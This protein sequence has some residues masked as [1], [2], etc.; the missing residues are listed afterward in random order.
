MSNGRV[1]SNTKVIRFKFDSHGLGDVCHAA[2]VM[3]LY[4]SSGYDVALQVEDNKRWV[5]QAAGVPIYSGQDELPDHPYLYPDLDRFWDLS[6][7]DHTFSKIAHFLEFSGLPT[8]GPKEDV[9]KRLCNQRIDATK[10]VSEGAMNSARKLTDALPSPIFLVHTKGSNWQREKSIPDATAF[11]VIRELAD[12][13]KGVVTLDW[14]SR[15]PTLDHAN[16]RAAGRIPLDVFGALCLLADVFIGIDS[17]PFHLAAWFPIRTLY[18]TREIPPVRCCIPSPNATYLV[19]SRDA[20]HWNARGSVWRFRMFAGSEAT[21]ND[22]VSTAVFIEQS[23]NL[24]DVLEMPTNESFCGKY[25][26][27][28]LG[29]D[30]RTIELLPNGRIG[31]GAGDCERKWHS[32][33]NGGRSWIWLS[34]RHGVICEC[35]STDGTLFQGR[36][37]QFERM[38]IELKRQSNLPP[39]TRLRIAMIMNW[40]NDYEDVAS[41]VLSNRREYASDQDYP[42]LETHY[43]GSWGKLDA[44]LDAWDHYDW[45]FWLDADACITNKSQKVQD[46]LSEDA[47]VILTCDRNGISAGSMLIRTAPAL[48]EIIEDIRS[49]REE[50]D[51]PNGLWEQNGLMWSLW[52]IKDCVKIIP[53]QAMNSYAAEQYELGSHVWEPGDFVLHCA[54]LPNDKKMRLL[55]AAVAATKEK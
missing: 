28:R 7:P 47:D 14:D 27:R 21:A 35:Q 19:P 41:V 17:G 26:Y 40:D 44:L 33:T 4:M 51:W 15:S 13:G 42:L 20:E 18:V 32:G 37:T 2:A 54:G 25:T 12:S 34:G 50:F 3:R 24:R 1:V 43:N 52:K 31:E 30:E 22:I 39:A 11:D 6:A 48:R 55:S 49:R 9:W 53:Q 8:L 36:W 10:A 38:P 46:L 16:V 5:W 29:H 23:P 45:L